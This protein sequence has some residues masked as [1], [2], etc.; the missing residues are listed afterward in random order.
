M[1]PLFTN[2]ALLAGLAGIT[3][4]VLIHLLLRRKSQRLRF[5]TSQFFVKQDEQSM[6]KRKL[7]NLFLLAARCLLFALIVLGFTRPYLP[8]A[9][10]GGAVAKRQQ[11]VLVLDASVSMQANGTGGQQWARAR[12][13]ARKTLAGLAADDRAALIAC[14]TQPNTIS[15][16]APPSV[17]AQKL[18]DL[19]PTWG[20]GDLADAVRQATRMLSVNNP[21]FDTTLYV[22]SDLQRGGCQ[23]LGAAPVNNELKVRVLDLGERFIPNLSVADLHLTAQGQTGPRAVVTSYADDNQPGL[24]ATFKL[25]GK[26]VFARPV[27][28]SAGGTTNVPLTVPA[29]KPGWHS[30]E[31]AVETRDGLPAD[32]ARFATLFIPEPIHSVVVETRG[33]MRVFQQESFFVAT[34]LAPS[35]GSGEAS[36]SRF[37]YEKV[38]PEGIAAKVKTAAGQP[39]VGFVALPAARQLSTATISALTSYVQGGGGLLLFLGDGVSAGRYN[40]DLREL[41]PAQLER[42]ESAREDGP[43]WRIAQ[44]DKKSPLF[45][46]FREVNS[47]NLFLPEFT[48]RFQLKPVAGASTVAEYDDGVPFVIERKV[49]KGR[50]VLVNTSADTAWTDWPK[51][52]TF[53]PWLHAAGHYLAGRDA[54]HDVEAQPGFASGDSADFELGLPRQQIK[55]QRA[56]GRELT[57]AT[58]DQGQLRD[59]PLDIP[60]IYT[61]K[62]AD[63]REL[64]RIAVNFPAA[65]SDL[66]MM[67]PGELDQQLVRKTEPQDPTLMAGLFGESNHGKELWRVLLLAALV[68]MLVEPWIANRTLA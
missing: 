33:S 19:Q 41:L 13:L 25:D 27:A 4:P 45:A 21:R 29:L 65:E 14:A 61:L 56:G 35:Q 43:P 1:F 3:A 52:K 53:V 10:G 57:M 50:V 8:G 5:S 62:T 34:A 15:E 7:R 2:I 38:G 58:D 40:T 12:E 36:A 59:V 66:A 31:F 63:G 68:V 55:V 20:T 39:P 16:F 64:R 9:T 42:V 44:Y 28:L 6:R 49:G 22:I 18:A 30:A 17:V 51:H 60:G 67:T 46:V 32:D 37:A 26:E 47:G 23:N 54:G 11:A 24:R 48:R